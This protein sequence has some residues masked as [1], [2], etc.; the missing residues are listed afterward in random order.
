MEVF[1]VGDGRIAQSF[2]ALQ[3]VNRAS[4]EG[5]RALE[6]AGPSGG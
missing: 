1:G 4:M 2:Q 3:V 5:L 6:I